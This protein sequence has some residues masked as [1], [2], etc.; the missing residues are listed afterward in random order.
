M[1]NATS[2]EAR[3][4]LSAALGPALALPASLVVLFATV[5][6]AIL[7]FRYSFNHYD[8][9]VLMQTAFTFENYVKFFSDK[10]FLAVLWTTIWMSFV[11]TA[12]SLVLGFPLAWALARTQSRF[13]N[14]LLMGLIFPM[15]VGSVVRMV[16]WMVILGNSGF[17]N[18]VFHA[19]HFISHPL[20]ILYTPLA[21][22][23]GLTSFVLPYMVLTLQGVLEGIDFSIEEAAH[24]LGAGPVKTFVRIIGPVAAPGVAAGSMLVFILCMNAY[25]TPVLLGGTRVT[26]MAPTV[27]NQI[28]HVSNWPFGAALALLLMITT[29]AL[30]LGSHWLIQR[31]YAKTMAT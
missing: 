18:T 24:N 29:L 20:R 31:N 28:S 27:Y 12:L 8:P 22:I 21:V 19:L 11:C 26:M 1:T 5:I 10:Y 6:P 15:L 4:A 25:V 16:G 14:L 13:K 23:L 9:S 17:A 2:P 30:A 7:L 3:R